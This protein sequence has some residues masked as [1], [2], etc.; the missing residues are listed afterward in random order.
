MGNLPA[1]EARCA[2]A[3]AGKRSAASM[4]RGASR[5]PIS[6]GSSRDDLVRDCSCPRSAR[7][8]GIVGSTPPQPSREQHVTEP[9]L[10]GSTIR[11][12]SGSR[13]HVGGLVHVSGRGA[14]PTQRPEPATPQAEHPA[15]ADLGSR[16]AGP[17]RYPDQ[18]RTS[19]TVSGGAFVVSAIARVIDCTAR[20]PSPMSSERIASPTS[21][22]EG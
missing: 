7:S 21:S 1:P 4:F 9:A 5:P 13:C 12:L 18:A 14:K 6:G 2:P 17:G 22:T 15:P 19:L 20:P 3:S 16:S 10:P 8:M 11:V